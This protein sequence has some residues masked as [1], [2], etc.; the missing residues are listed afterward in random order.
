MKKQILFLF[1]LFLSVNVFAYQK[2][3]TPVG[4]TKSFELSNINAII[5]PEKSTDNLKKSAEDLKKY[6]SQIYSVD[7]VVLPDSNANNHFIS[8]GDT[9]QFKICG[10]KADLNADGYSIQY[11][12]GNIFIFGGYLSGAENGVYALLEED[13]GCRFWDN[14]GSETI[15]VINSKEIKFVPRDYNPPFITRDPWSYEKAGEDY[16]RRNRL[17]GYGAWGFV[18]TSF[19]YVPESNFE[20]HPEWF[21]MVKGKREPKQLCYSNPEVIDQIY[22]FL[23]SYMDAY[24][25]ESYAVSPQDGHPLCDCPVCNELDEKEGTKA[26]TLI[27]ALNT[28]CERLEKD[29]P[30]KKLVTLAYLDYI[31]PPKTIKPHQN[32]IIQICS[33]C[34]D[35]PYPFFAYNETDKFQRDIQNWVATGC[36]T[37]TWNYVV[38]F[39]HYLIPSPNTKLVA[40]N[41]KLLNDYNVDGVFLQGNYGDGIRDSG[42]LKT[43]I[44]AKLLWNPNLDYNYLL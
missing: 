17:R 22:N 33:D 41:I 15:P 37:L 19:T 1:I 21:S 34:A 30:N 24:D 8:I 44:W 28:V 43:W 39:D 29:H 3:L 40:N 31:T 36:E 35:W 14:R 18:H 7:F 6:L 4:K 25:F 38:N 32:L 42:A 20:A 2:T 26:A 10:L 5:I 13:L 11:K 27:K 12:D 16:G 23:K 9:E